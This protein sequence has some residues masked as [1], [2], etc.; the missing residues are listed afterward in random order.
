MALQ[1]RYDGFDVPPGNQYCSMGLHPWYLG[2]V[3][4]Q[5][6]LLAHYA[7]HRQVLAIGECGLDKICTTPWALQLEAFRQQIALAEQLKK[8]LIVHCVRAYTEIMA[9]L[10]TV[11]VPV[12]IHGFQKKPELAAA[13]LGQGFY[14]SFGKALLENKAQAAASLAATTADRFFLE[15][16]HAALPIRRIYEA[17]SEIRKTGPDELILQLQKNFKTVFT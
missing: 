4:A 9:L 13:L 17:A 5:M 14:L 15:T 10:K 16:D 12:I 6:A 2:E 7:R 3:S 1:N 11:V 8:P